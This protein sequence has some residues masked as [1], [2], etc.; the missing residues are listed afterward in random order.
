VFLGVKGIKNL[1]L[2]CFPDLDDLI[3]YRLLFGAVSAN[4]GSK[5]VMCHFEQ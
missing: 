2:K 4:L 5:E 1:K 3:I